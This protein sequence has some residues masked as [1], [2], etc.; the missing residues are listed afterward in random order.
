MAASD[1]KLFFYAGKTVYHIAMKL[2]ALCTALVVAAGV[3]EARAQSGYFGIGVSKAATWTS[4]IWRLQI[5]A[6]NIGGTTTLNS[7]A[8]RRVS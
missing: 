8:I 1:Y 4:T 5:V 3:S 6:T 7:I 2:K